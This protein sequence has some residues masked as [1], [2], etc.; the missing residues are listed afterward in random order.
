MSA[1]PAQPEPLDQPVLQRAVCPFDTTLGVG[2]VCATN[3]DVLLI[4]GVSKLGDVMTCFSPLLGH[5]KHRILVGI[6][7]H[8]S[9]MGRQV[10]IQRVGIG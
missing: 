3:L 4:Q 8:R 9:A 1:I 10:Q 5:T 7:R 2:A 6:E